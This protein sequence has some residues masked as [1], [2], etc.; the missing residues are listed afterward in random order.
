MSHFQTCHARLKI[1]TPLHISNGQILL[2]TKDF[3]IQQ[4][5][6]HRIDYPKLLSQIPLE[7]WNKM[8]HQQPPMIAYV[9]ASMLQAAEIYCIPLIPYILSQPMTISPEKTNGI[10]AD[11]HFDSKIHAMALDNI[12]RS[13]IPG[14][15]LKGV[16]RTALY[17]AA[18]SENNQCLERLRLTWTQDPLQTSYPLD[19]EMSGADFNQP[20]RDIFR[21]LQVRDSNYQ[22]A[23]NVLTVYP[24]HT[25]HL[26]WGK[27]IPAFV[28]KKNASACLWEMIQPGREFQCE[29]VLDTWLQHTMR[30]NTATIQITLPKIIQALQQWGQNI[31]EHEL[32]FAQ[33]YHIAY[34]QTF[35]QQILQ[36]IINSRDQK[37]GSGNKAYFPLGAGIPWHGKTVGTMMD[38]ELTKAVC[39]HHYRYMG[40][41][42]HHVP[43]CKA[44]LKGSQ[45][46]HGICPHCGQKIC[47][48][49]LINITP[50]PKTRKIVMIDGNPQYPPGWVELELE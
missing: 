4:G 42:A 33:N 45:V 37:N 8:P 31:A 43:G 44:M 11:T 30:Q 12:C 20:H 39:R 16:I 49:Q 26:V 32:Q 2:E 35:Y 27:G 13:F 7:L 36:Q 14:S 25:F 21:Q 47:S 5:V 18:L 50:F 38:E 46:K 10:I 22:A 6:L 17:A 41:F 1:L 40:K 3:Y 19:R 23:K 28:G 34:L 9:P 24:V 29:I 48:D 15:T